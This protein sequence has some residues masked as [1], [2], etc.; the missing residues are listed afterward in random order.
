MSKVTNGN[1]RTAIIVE[2]DVSSRANTVYV[3]ITPDDDQGYT[4]SY[5]FHIEDSDWAYCGA[6][7]NRVN[8]DPVW[9]FTHEEA[10]SVLMPLLP[11]PEKGIEL[12][13]QLGLPRFYGTHQRIY[14]SKASKPYK[15]V[16][17]G[18]ENVM[19]VPVMDKDGKL[20][21]LYVPLDIAGWLLKEKEGS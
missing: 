1:G 19:C 18:S 15:V 8:N 10:K 7:Y 21:V 16:F 20:Y 6:T 2:V 9:F 3:N 13:K 4:E 12:L 11:D 17:H 5:V 14:V